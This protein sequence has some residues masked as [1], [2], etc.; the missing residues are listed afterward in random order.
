[1][2]GQTMYVKS[3]PF[4]IVSVAAP[5]FIGLEREKATDIPFNRTSGSLSRMTHA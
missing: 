4:T 5:G 1:V 2:L 3:V